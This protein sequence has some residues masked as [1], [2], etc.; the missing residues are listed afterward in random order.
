M[1]GVSV[2]VTLGNKIIFNY[3]FITVVYKTDDN[4]FDWQSI[5]FKEQIIF[6]LVF[7]IILTVCGDKLNRIDLL[8]IEHRFNRCACEKKL[9]VHRKIKHFLKFYVLN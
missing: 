3:I 1:C 7:K 6:Y 8:R 2:S 5:I 4:I 9:V